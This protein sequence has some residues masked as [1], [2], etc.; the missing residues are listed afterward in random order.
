MKHI[1]L[2]SAFLLLLGCSCT[3]RTAPQSAFTVDCTEALHTLASFYSYSTVD[4]CE[5]D[6]RYY[7]PYNCDWPEEIGNR[8]L[9]EFPHEQV[10]SY[11]NRLQKAK[12]YFHQ[13]TLPLRAVAPID[14]IRQLDHTEAMFDSLF[15]YTVSQEYYMR[16]YVDCYEELIP[17][18]ID[19]CFS[20]LNNNIHH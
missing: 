10:G 16:L 1:T 17:A 8:I 2:F 3:N 13:Q 15:V 11:W 7:R 19:K 9:P 18:E 12:T 20:L 4:W 14:A 6:A 5:L